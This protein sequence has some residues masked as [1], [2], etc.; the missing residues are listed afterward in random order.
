MQTS[1]KWHIQAIILAF[2]DVEDEVLVKKRVM[3]INYFLGTGDAWA[4]VRVIMLPRLA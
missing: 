1:G 4:V 2:P 3:F